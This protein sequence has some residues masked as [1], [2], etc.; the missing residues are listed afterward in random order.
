LSLSPWAYLP[1]SSFILFSRA[2][3]FLTSRNTRVCARRTKH[4]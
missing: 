4:F 3:I 1:I 2:S